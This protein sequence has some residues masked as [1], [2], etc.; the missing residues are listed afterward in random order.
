[1]AGREFDKENTQTRN[2]GSI[3]SKEFI[4]GA[5]IGGLVGAA[6]ALFF[7]PKSG[8]DLRESIN[9]QAGLV[10]EKS[11]QLRENVVNKSSEIV[12]MT[13]EKTSALTQ[14]VAQQSTDLV[15]KAKNLTGNG[16]KE[17][18]GNDSE[19]IS[20]SNPTSVSASKDFD[21]LTLSDDLDVQEK[22]EEAKRA[23]DEEESKIKN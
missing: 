4:A 3:G 17:G 11:S 9:Q 16:V 23:F 14:T 8:K 13:K 22:L 15:N 21:D 5:V 1:M 7:S 18:Q 10:L 12:S 2:E 6:A 19:Y 20:I